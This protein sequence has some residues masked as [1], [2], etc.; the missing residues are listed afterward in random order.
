MGWWKS[1]VMVLG[2]HTVYFA[3]PI[4]AWLLADAELDESKQEPPSQ[5]TQL[6]DFVTRL[7]QIQFHDRQL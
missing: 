5:E 3:S 7:E 4:N 1:T 6:W 2:T